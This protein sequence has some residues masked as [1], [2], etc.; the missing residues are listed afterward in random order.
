MR[1]EGNI[2]LLI[3]SICSKYQIT[4]NYFN[5]LIHDINGLD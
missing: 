3:T 4:I 2:V 5:S 1:E